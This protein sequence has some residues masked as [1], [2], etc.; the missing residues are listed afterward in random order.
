MTERERDDRLP[1]VSVTKIP[2]P[3]AEMTGSNGLPGMSR[4]TIGSF[5]GKLQAL[6]WA[7]AGAATSTARR[8]DARNLSCLSAFHL[9]N[10]V[11][12]VLSVLIEI[13]Y[14]EAIFRYPVKSMRGERLEVAELGWHGID[15]DRRL[16]FRR[17]DDHSG[18]PWLTASKLPDLI[19]YAP[20]RGEE[21]AQ[22]EL[23]THVRTPDGEEP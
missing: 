20:H 19:L 4:W 21:G 18:M 3:S 15:G 14:V 6:P 10:V 5:A 23:P 2:Q 7:P 12:L 8:G 13:G 22:G 9:T 1:C 11:S 17:M 16:A